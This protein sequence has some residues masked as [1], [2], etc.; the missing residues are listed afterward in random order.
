M[1]SGPRAVPMASKQSNT[2]RDPD[3]TP[4][5]IAEP[6][7][8]PR[9]PIDWLFLQPSILDQLHDSII[10]TDLQGTITGCNQAAAHMF[11]YTQQELIG[12]N[13]TIFYPEEG[14]SEKAVKPGAHPSCKP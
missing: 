8:D 4:R 6:A 14:S 5:P 3:V 13:V 12:R 11:G 1:A 10:I 7:A 2:S 9:T